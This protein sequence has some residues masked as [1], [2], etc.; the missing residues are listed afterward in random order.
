MCVWIGVYPKP[1][2]RFM[3]AAVMSTVKITNPKSA[4]AEEAQMKVY[5][6][7]QEAAVAP[8]A[9]EASAA[10]EQHAGHGEEMERE[11]AGSVHEQPAAHMEE[12]GNIQEHTAPQGHGGGH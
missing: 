3:D 8:D 11:S 4:A 1:F 2:L 9:H 5:T 7:R 6:T 12:Q 10:I